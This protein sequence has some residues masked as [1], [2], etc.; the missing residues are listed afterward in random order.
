MPKSVKVAV[1]HSQK[2]GL[3]LGIYPQAQWEKAKK[4][5]KVAESELHIFKMSFSGCDAEMCTAETD[6]TDETMELLR[7]GGGIM[8]LALLA[9]KPVGYPVPLDGFASAEA[10]PPKTRAE[11]DRARQEKIQEMTKSQQ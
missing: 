9:G 5:E 10:G 4:N 7:S 11:Y 1:G 6:V 8:V 3:K 2:A